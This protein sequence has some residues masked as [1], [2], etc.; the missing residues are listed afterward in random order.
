[1]LYCL[2]IIADCHGLPRS[3]HKGGKI[4]PVV[5]VAVFDTFFR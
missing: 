2:L 5:L 1:M 4:K 3:L